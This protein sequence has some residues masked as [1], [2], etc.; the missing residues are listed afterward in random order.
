MIVGEILALAGKDAIRK[1][2]EES[3]DVVAMIT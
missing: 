1:P 2:K 3:E